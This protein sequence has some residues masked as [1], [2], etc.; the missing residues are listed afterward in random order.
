MFHDAWSIHRD[1]NENKKQENRLLL[2][3]IWWDDFPELAVP[4][5]WSNGK[6][7]GAS[8][9]AAPCRRTSWR[10]V[11]SRIEL[12]GR[13]KGNNSIQH[14]CLYYMLKHDTQFCHHYRVI[15]NTMVQRGSMG[16]HVLPKVILPLIISGL[17][18]ISE[19]AAIGRPQ[20]ATGPQKCCID[21]HKVTK[22]IFLLL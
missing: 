3:C 9:V 5:H 8:C 12:K 17:F 20:F 11:N 21:T 4:T 7:T 10:A 18:F 16:Q 19:M 6:Q 15:N 14:R 1:K 2:T 22:Y 13:E